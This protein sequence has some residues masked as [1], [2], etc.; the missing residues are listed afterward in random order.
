MKKNG[1]TVL[2]L[3]VSFALAATIGFFLLKITMIIK[4]LYTMSYIKT[5][6]ILY[7]R[8]MYYFPP[9]VQ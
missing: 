6:I 3:I 7:T 5:N 9:Q 2:E 4:N 1:F 8:A